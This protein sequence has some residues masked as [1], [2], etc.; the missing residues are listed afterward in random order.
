MVS[1]YVFLYNTYDLHIRANIGE[2]YPQELAFRLPG[3]KHA[4]S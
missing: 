2:N 3:A 1:P 4:H